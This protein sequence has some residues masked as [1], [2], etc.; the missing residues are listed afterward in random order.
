M[1]TKIVHFRSGPAGWFFEIVFYLFNLMM[2]LAIIVLT[3]RSGD[4]LAAAET[5]LA[6]GLA[7]FGAATKLFVLLLIWVAGDV[8]LGSLAVISRGRKAAIEE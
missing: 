7:G 8:I 2:A 1:M 6:K 3:V 5:E 4:I